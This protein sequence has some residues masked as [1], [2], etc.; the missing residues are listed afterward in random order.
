MSPMSN[1]TSAPK[2]LAA[3]SMTQAERRN[4]RIGR[5]IETVEA[6]VEAKDSERVNF[7]QEMLD[8]D[9]ARNTA[10]A[11]TL[12]KTEAKKRLR[13]AAAA[14]RAANPQ[15]ASNC[16]V[17]FGARTIPVATTVQ[18]SHHQAMPLGDDLY[19]IHHLNQTN[20]DDQLLLEGIV[21]HVYFTST[22]P[23]AE[24]QD[25]ITVWTGT[26]TE[27]PVIMF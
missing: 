22:G 26:A 25:I 16:L 15:I 23:W 24:L 7:Y 6:A 21:V 9:T 8:Q 11:T 4:I 19:D 14:A 27:E 1:T 3:V 17:E 18:P 20:L 10:E 2:S 12:S 13:R 5:I